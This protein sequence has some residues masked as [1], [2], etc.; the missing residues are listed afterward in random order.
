MQRFLVICFGAALFALMGFEAQGQS[1][2]MTFEFDEQ[3]VQARPVAFKDTHIQLAVQGGGYTNVAWG[4]LSQET[5]QR[6]TNLPNYR[7]F[8]TPFLD[9]RPMS[10]PSAPKITVKEVRRMDRPGQGGWMSSPVMWLMLFLVYV[11][12]I[13]AGYE[14]AIYRQR[15]PAVV[16]SVAAA[17][18]VVGPVIFLALP[19]G[20]AKEL[21]AL[22]G[23]EGEALE[24][25]TEGA[26]GEAGQPAEAEAEAETAK[27]PEAK[28]AT[29]VFDKGKFTFNR[30]FFETRL[31]GFLKTIP[32]DPTKVLKVVSARGTHVGTRITRLTPNELS[33]HVVKG[34]ASED[35]IIP[36]LEI[37]QIMVQSKDAA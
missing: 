7:A 27:A 25:G 8:A 2:Y 32:E 33:L 10:P 16:C 17:A 29:T 31:A 20:L 28:A 37:S 14:I 23:E 36:F 3:T 5:L 21:E 11:A 22:E 6:L 12:N 18:P 4:R 35:V 24:E 1:G 15:P 19:S 26:E 13:Y 30:R 34:P 9:P